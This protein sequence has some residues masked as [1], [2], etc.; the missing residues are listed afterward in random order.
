MTPAGRRWRISRDRL[1]RDL[2]RAARGEDEA[3]R[4]G[5]E[6]DGEERVLLVGDAADLDEHRARGY[7]TPSGSPAYIRGPD[8]TRSHRPATTS[9]AVRAGRARLAA[10]RRRS[11]SPTSCCTSSPTT[12]EPG[13]A[14]ATAARVR[15]VGLRRHRTDRAAAATRSGPGESALVRLRRVARVPQPLRRDAG[16]RGR[17]VGARVPA[18]PTVP[19]AVPHRHVRRVRHVRAVP[20]DPAVARQPARRHAPHRAHRASDVAR[21]RARPTSPRSSARRA[22]TRSRWARCRRCTRRGRSCCWSSSGRSPAGG[23]PC[24]SPTR[25]AMAFTLVYT[26]DHFVFDILLGWTYVI[27]VVLAFRYLGT[28][29]ARSFWRG[30]PAAISRR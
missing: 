3:E 5:A 22:S 30:R 26:A 6:G 12:L 15:R 25:S 19:R 9:S 8:G 1:G 29:P 14:R 7:R 16:R 10:D 18:V 13:R 20:G 27:V 17:A 11:S 4:V 23:A 2:A 28:T 24:S 21:A